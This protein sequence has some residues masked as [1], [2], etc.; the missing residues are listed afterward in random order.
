MPQTMS[1]TQG[2]PTRIW[3]VSDGT[4]GMRLQSVAL[5]EALVRA[6]PDWSFDDFII[7]PHPLIRTLPRLAAMLPGLP[8]YG[9]AQKTAGG[10]GQ[11]TLARR[12]HAGH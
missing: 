12:P 11:G 8:L 2:T 6:R 10:G 3:V 1:S 9:A 7:T 5:A 4:A